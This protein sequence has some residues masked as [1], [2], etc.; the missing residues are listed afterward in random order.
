MAVTHVKR[1]AV[2]EKTKDLLPW[3]YALAE[4]DPLCRW[5]SSGTRASSPGGEPE[6]KYPTDDRLVYAVRRQ[7]LGCLAW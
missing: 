2:R 4:A 3:G 5:R 6:H 7:L 1:S